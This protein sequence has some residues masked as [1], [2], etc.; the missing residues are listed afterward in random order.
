MPSDDCTDG[1]GSHIDDM[2]DD[3][4]S[5]TGSRERSNSPVESDLL[6][7]LT[8]HIAPPCFTDSDAMESTDMKQSFCIDVTSFVIEKDEYLEGVVRLIQSDCP[9]VV[10]DMKSFVSAMQK[11]FTNVN[12]IEPQ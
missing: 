4:G 9:E 2:V 7:Y 3:N 10:Q 6:R 5:N 12:G 1:P 8:V 11:A